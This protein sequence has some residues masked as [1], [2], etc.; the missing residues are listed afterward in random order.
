MGIA[1]AILARHLA[2]IALASHG[3]AAV[4]VAA[5]DRQRIDPTLLATNGRQH[6]AF[7]AAVFTLPLAGTAAAVAL[8]RSI[9]VASLAW[10]G[11]V[12]VTTRR[13]A[14]LLSFAVVAEVVAAARIADHA[15]GTFHERTMSTR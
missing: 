6:F 10:H 1:S 9:A 15:T 8:N 5:L 13:A 7:T 11:A 2:A 3:P 4:A 12:T 14:F